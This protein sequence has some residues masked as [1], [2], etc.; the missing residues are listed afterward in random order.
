MARWKTHVEFL[1]CVIDLI[2]LS[3]MVEALQGKVCQNS[4]PPGGV[5]QLELR[6]KGKGSFPCQY[7]DTT[8]TAIDCTTTLSLTV[9]I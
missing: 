1:L 9:F 6:F 2:F 3:F 5:D 4:L 8:R 7:I